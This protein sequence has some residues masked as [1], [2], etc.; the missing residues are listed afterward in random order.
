MLYKGI[1]D[2]SSLLHLCRQKTR[3]DAHGEFSKHFFQQNKNA[4]FRFRNGNVILEDI[5]CIRLVS[6][7]PQQSTD[8]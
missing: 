7:L 6:F 5:G 4:T 2:F 1:L 3:G 8:V